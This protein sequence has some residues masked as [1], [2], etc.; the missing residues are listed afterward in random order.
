MIYHFIGTRAAIFFFM[1][2][3]FKGWPPHTL[4]KEKN[5]IKE[6]GTWI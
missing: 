1:N 5:K 6:L 2:F 3:F 4:L